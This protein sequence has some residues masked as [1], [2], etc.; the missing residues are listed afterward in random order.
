MYTNDFLGNEIDI[1]DYFAYYVAS[2]KHHQLCLFQ[3]KGLTDKGRA[4]AKLLK[5]SSTTGWT[6]NRAPLGVRVWDNKLK[7]FR[8]TTDDDRKK[9]AN[10]LFY[11]EAMHERSIKLYNFKEAE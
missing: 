4:K 1:D 9:Q 5:R 6:T 7:N 2:G 10:K 3:F 11:L 8:S